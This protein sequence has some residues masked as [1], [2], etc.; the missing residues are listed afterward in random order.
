MNCRPL[1]VDTINSP[2]MPEPLTPS[3]LLTMKSKVILPPPGEFQ[4]ADLYSRKRWRRVQFLVNEFWMRWRKD[5]LQSLQ[6]RQKWVATRRNLHVGDIVIM[7][8]NNLPR[9]RWKLALVEETYPDDDGLVRKVRLKI[10]D[11]NLD[12][13]GRPT[14]PA[15]RLCRPVQKLI[16]LLSREEYEDRGIPT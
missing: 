5:Y 4:R 8:D 3:H 13:N 12:K 15:T 11:R 6:P 2:Q 14:G 1:T 10:A 9:N 7:K 16:L